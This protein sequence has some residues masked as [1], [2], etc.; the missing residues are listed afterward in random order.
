MNTLSVA[1]CTYNGASFLQEQLNSILGQTRLPDELVARDD[2]S[3]DATVQVLKRFAEM[4]PFPVRIL[5]TG[6]N[7]GYARNFERVIM[8]CDGDL[9]ALSDQDDVWLPAKLARLEEALGD[10]PDRLL[11]FSDACLVDEKLRPLDQTLWESLQING[12]RMQ[13]IREGGPR[14]HLYRYPAVTGATAC[15]RR[16]LADQALPADV[17]FWHDAW[18]A[19][20]AELLGRVVP[21]EEPLILYRQHSENVVGAPKAVAPLHVRVGNVLR[22]NPRSEAALRATN[23]Q[24]RQFYAAAQRRARRE[25]WLDSASDGRLS[26]R[27]RHATFR[28]EPGPRRAR[29]FRVARELASGRYAQYSGGVRRALVMAARDLLR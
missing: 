14:S 1:L 22:R 9:V 2:G 20:V 23:D 5:P 17:A 25:G 15:F 12:A 6:E 19:L 24:T 4:A 11:A 8:A 3:T 10:D 18:L 27:V 16:S 28:A 13:S 7:L 29:P 21:I 26:E